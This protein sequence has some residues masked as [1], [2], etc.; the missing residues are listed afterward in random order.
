MSSAQEFSPEQRQALLR[1]AHESILSAF[2]DQGLPSSTPIEGLSEPRGVFTTLYLH[3][4]LRGCVGY[5]VATSPIYLAVAETARAAAFDDSRF[6]PVTIQE[7][8]ELE[9]SL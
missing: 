2:S 9:V 1:I 5:A 3:G 7:A 4:S 6:K 8:K